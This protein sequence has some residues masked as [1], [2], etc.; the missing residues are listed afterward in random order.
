MNVPVRRVSNFGGFVVGLLL[1]ISPILAQSDMAAD[2]VVSGG[3]LYTMNAAAPTAEAMAILGGRIVGVGDDDD[4][5]RRF[6]GPDTRIEDVGGKVVIPGLIDAHAHLMNLGEFL[7]NLDLI[8]TTSAEEIGGMVRSAASAT[9]P[10]VWIRG[11]GWDQNDWAIQEFPTRELLDELEGVVQPVYLRRVDNHAAWVNTRALEI[12]GVDSATPDPDDG[13]IVRDAD[14]APTGVLVDGAM[15]L[16]LESIPA[17]D[18]AELEAWLEAAQEHVVSVGV[19]GVHTMGE[20]RADTE[21]YTRLDE[22]GRLVPRVVLY[23]DSNEEGVLEWWRAEGA[24]TMRPTEHLRIKGV[25]LYA[26]GALGSRGAALLEPYADDP[27]NSGILVTSPDELAAL[28]TE[29]I[30]LGLQPVTHAIGDRGNRIAL[31]AVESA[32]EAVPHGR[33]TSR[34]PRIE[35]AQV[36]AP[37]DFA[38]FANLGVVASVQPTHATSD[39]Y[40]A[41]DRVGSERIEGA[42][43]WRTLREAGAK[44]ACGSDFPVESANPFYGLYAA[45]ARQDHDNWPD[46]GWYTDQ[47]MTR[48][49]A[50]ACFTVDAASVVGMHNEVGTL[51]VGRWADYVVIDRDILSVPMEEVWQTR[52]LQ[53]VVGGETVYRAP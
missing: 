18:P 6:A 34:A 17:P 43:A 5:R 7:A 11:W 8:G 35:H 42:Y 44:L 13:R 37:D 48:E 28:T 15:R 24:I 45:M 27:G 19:T 50:L 29:V 53:T 38:R 47:R 10:D 9:P 36:V 25:K 30:E 26:D 46:G 49:E 51:A 23:L 41:E 32:F 31:D 22:A 52:A 39:M 1:P 33:S 16:V 40:W 4:I 3:T 14:G 12:A 20:T 21:A 2:I